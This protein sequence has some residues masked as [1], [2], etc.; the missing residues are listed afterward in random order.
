MDLSIV[1]VSWRVRDLLSQCLK[2]IYENTEGLDLEVFV[3]DND[4]QDGTADL[5][6][7]KFPQVHLIANKF[8][9][10]FAKANNQALRLARGNYVLLLNPD[11]QILPG[12]FKSMLKFMEQNPNYGLAGCRLLNPDN[13]LQPSVRRFPSFWDQFLLLL[14]VPHLLP[15]LSVFKKYLAKDF[16]Y[17]EPA[18]VDQIMGAFFWLRKEVLEKVGLLDEGFWIWF[19]EVDY[20]RRLHN[21]GW[22]IGYNPDAEIIHHFGQSF[23]QRLGLEK[24]KIFNHSLSRYF[25]KHHSCWTYWGIQIARP[26]SLILAWAHQL[27]TKK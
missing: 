21:S 16:D 20:C 5:V 14:K 8:N 6:R 4:S 2:S 26:L 3:V 9:Q 7:Y 15:N 17:E 1:I 23:K 12:N 19:E 25:K 27:I 22:K 11:T 18:E 13:S 24:Q 10:G